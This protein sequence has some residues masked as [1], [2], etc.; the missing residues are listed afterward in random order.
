MIPS[1]VLK[2]PPI[3]EPIS[4]EEVKS[5]SRITISDDDLLIQN[6]IIGIR[7]MVEDLFHLALITQTWTM[8]LDYLPC[9]IEIYKR[10][11]QKINSVKYLDAAGV[12]QTIA[13]NQ[14]MVDLNSKPPRIMPAPNASWPS[15]NLRPS[16]VAVEFD[17]GYG[18]DGNSVPANVL[19]Y[20]MMTLG[21]FYENRESY[22][23]LKLNHLDFTENLMSSERLLG[24]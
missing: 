22:S 15:V 6:Q 24:L 18:P 4:I 14:Y 10:P 20:L 13:A 2:T 12:S 17:A 1:F 3:R 11:I 23:E 16:A 8:Y 7:K 21:N 9:E 5:H 19:M